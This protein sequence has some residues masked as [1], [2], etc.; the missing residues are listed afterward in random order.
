M[1]GRHA[2]M[3]V[4]TSAYVAADAKLAAKLNDPAWATATPFERKRAELAVAEERRVLR[5]AFLARQRGFVESAEK[6]WKAHAPAALQRAAAL[7]N[8]ARAEAI[9]QLCQGASVSELRA[10]A[11]ALLK[12]GD[13]SGAYGMRRALAALGPEAGAE[14]AEVHAIA[15]RAGTQASEPRLRELVRCRT[16][17]AQ[18]VGAA[19]G[20][21]NPSEV[22]R[23]V[24]SARMLPGP[25]G[26]ERRASVKE[27][28]ALIE[29]D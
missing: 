7:D 16:A 19:D 21:L 15:L 25:D 17:W 22:L 20:I 11:E 23:A 3:D 9:K 24:E 27:I 26:G 4:N 18:A 14:A 28:E 29:A 1:N 12:A 6:E 2:V 5:E 8:P 13:G 10:L